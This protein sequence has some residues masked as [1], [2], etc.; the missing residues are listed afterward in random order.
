V[1]DTDLDGTNDG[2][3]ANGGSDP[4]DPDSFP[5][6]PPFAARLIAVDPTAGTVTIE[7]N[8]IDN[9]TANY[10]I[11]ASD[12]LIGDPLTSWTE[13]ATF[14]FSTGA[15]TTFTETRAGSGSGSETLPSPM[16]AK[17]FYVIYEYP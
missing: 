17:R 16:P 10:D 14:V 15:T 13:V 3:E 11:Y 8:S 2:D 12:T 6:P 1:A 7:W 4:T 9:G 5:A